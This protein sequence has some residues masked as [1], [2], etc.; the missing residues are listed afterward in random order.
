[1]STWRLFLGALV[2]AGM[3][4]APPRARAY[5]FTTITESAV[6]GFGAPSL[7]DDGTAAFAAGSGSFQAI[8][9][10]N[11]GPLTTIADSELGFGLAFNSLG[12]PSINASG[13]V[14]FHGAFDS[15]RGIY[16]G[17][18]AVIVPIAR[19]FGPDPWAVILSDA[20]LNDGGQ[21]AFSGSREPGSLAYVRAD[22]GT[23]TEIGPSSPFPSN[24]AINAAG[25]V[26][27]QTEGTVYRGD[28]GPPTP[29]GV[30]ARNGVAING[31]GEVA[32]VRAQ[33][34][35]LLQPVGI[36]VG[37]GATQRVVADVLG[38]FMDF[39]PASI[40]DAGTVAFHAVLDTFAMGIFTG[41][42]PVAHRVIG[43]GDPL[44]GSTVDLLFFSPEG[45]NESGQI[46]FAASLADGRSGVYLA[47]IPEPGA[48]ALL[49][50]G[51]A[52]AAALRR[53]ARGASTA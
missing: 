43:F 50:G 31:A 22:G 11:G 47:T 34:L 21:V 25:Q 39:G 37:D 4:V 36:A 52:L 27:F 35:P 15:S 9:R 30:A 32:F 42:D 44:S 13:D 8:Y 1:M 14:A 46:A 49:A 41:P 38:P 28:G 3:L 18:G 7:A 48:G 20:V 51:I 2:V 5:V 33:S 45:L 23:F 12:S 26:A 16:V 10:G 53:A 24:P 19:T 29:I 40:N 17:D 6:L